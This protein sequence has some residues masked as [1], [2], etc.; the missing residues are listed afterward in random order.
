MATVAKQ[1]AA[2]LHVGGLPRELL[3]DELRA[4]FAPFG[5][6][7]SVEVLR[8]KPESPF[9][10]RDPDEAPDAGAEAG[11]RGARV[12]GRGARGR[13]A[14]REARR[15]SLPRLRVRRAHPLGCEIPQPMRHP[16]QRMQVEGRCHARPARQT[17]MERP[18]PHGTRGRR[19]RTRRCGDIRR[20]S[21][22]RRARQ[23]PRGRGS[24]LGGAD[25]EH[26]PIRRFLRSAA[27]TSS[28]STDARVIPR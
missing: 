23:T 18:P 6:V 14:R 15:A 7:R 5:A 10:R 16:V 11:G 24:V 3:D 19:A 13:R 27:A 22:R 20:G 21:R 2:R 28:R 9:H 4:R 8:E 17:P 12:G 1:P 25:A 26:A